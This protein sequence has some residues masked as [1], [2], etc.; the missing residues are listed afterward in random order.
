MNTVLFPYFDLIFSQY[1]RDQKITYLF[2]LPIFV[3]NLEIILTHHIMEMPHH[4]L[5]RP[6]YSSLLYLILHLSG[7]ECHN[8]LYSNFLLAPLSLL[9]LLDKCINKWSYGFTWVGKRLA[10]F[11]AISKCTVEIL[12]CV[13]FL[14]KH[15]SQKSG[16]SEAIF[17]LSVNQIVLWRKPWIPWLGWIQNIYHNHKLL[18]QV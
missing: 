4:L 8:Q 16:L 10:I 14:Q 13:G 18:F 5:L 3:F 12:I 11:V 6:S 7:L 9:P 15:R 2:W 17:R 1:Q